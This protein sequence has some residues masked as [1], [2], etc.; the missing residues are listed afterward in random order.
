MN[1]VQQTIETKGNLTQSTPPLILSSF[2]I[3]EGRGVERVILLTEIED[4][5]FG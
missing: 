3:D 5:E 2:F 1:L 4:I